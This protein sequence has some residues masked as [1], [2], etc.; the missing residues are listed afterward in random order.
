MGRIYERLIYIIP[1]ACIAALVVLLNSTD[2]GSIG[3]GGI[4]LVFIVIYIF[5]LS[6]F[7]VLLHAG[8]RVIQAM[9]HRRRDIDPRSWRIGVRKSYYIASV[10]AFIPVFLLAMQSIGQLQLRDL[11]LISLFELIAIFYIVKRG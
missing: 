3:P 8:S 10:L 6:S 1:A 2:P 9:I 11:A 5:F 7:F 4:L